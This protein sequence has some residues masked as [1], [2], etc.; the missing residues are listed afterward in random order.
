MK[1]NTFVVGFPKSGTT[2]LYEQL[3]NCD[4]VDVGLIKEPCFFSSD[5]NSDYK[6][7]KYIDDIKKYE[8]LYKKKA[9]INID[10]SPSYIH[11]LWAPSK[12]KQY[13]PNAKIIIIIREPFR[14]LES[15]YMQRLK[16][17]SINCSFE[18]YICDKKNLKLA[19]YSTL[20]KRYILTFEPKNIL[21][22]FYEDFLED[23]QRF[24]CNLCF[25]LDIPS[26]KVI[27]KRYNA[28]KRVRFFHFRT[29]VLRFYYLNRTFFDRITPP[30]IKSFIKFLLDKLT[31]VKKQDYTNKSLENFVKQDFREE[32]IKLQDQLRK[33][34]LVKSDFDLL[35]YWNY[36]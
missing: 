20:V 16:S 4:D 8:Q 10:I 1:V 11:S 2:A 17:G 36:K 30:F 6:N 28:S 22:L 15:A 31:L 23:N 19:Q 18:D 33:Y 13:N 9:R 32:I 21:V 7:Y 27:S 34:K 3:K 26:F 35:A 12:I 25:F 5:I 14:Y 29:K 24:I